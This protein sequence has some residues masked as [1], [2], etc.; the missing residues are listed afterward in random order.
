M[1]DPFANHVVRPR[2]FLATPTLD[3][4]LDGYAEDAE[5]RL[6]EVLTAIGIPHQRARV[7]G[8]SILP[9]ARSQLT[10]SF[11]ASNATHMLMRDADIVA[12]AHDVIA[13]LASGHLV[14][15]LPCTRR[16]LNWPKLVACAAA[17]PEYFAANPR[18][19]LEAAHVPNWE[20]LADGPTT[21]VGG[22][23]KVATLGTGCLLI[24]REVIEAIAARSPRVAVAHDDGATMAM[25]WD[26]DIANGLYIGEDVRMSH[27]ARAMGFDVQMLVGARTTHVGTFEYRCSALSHAEREAIGAHR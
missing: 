19:L 5:R 11:L 12:E 18:A 26:Y 7:H 20:W 9:I 25:I 16:A 24:A 22:F 1:N 2:L 10:N 17:E 27:I 4:R 23:A 3:G 8:C 13:L 14:C 15:G 21:V 6:T